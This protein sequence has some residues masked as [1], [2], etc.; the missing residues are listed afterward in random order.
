MGLTNMKHGQIRQSAGMR[1]V[2]FSEKESKMSRSSDGEPQI[3][4]GSI[5]TVGL[6]LMA[7]A[8]VYVLQS[9][10]HAAPWLAIPG[11]SLK[12][13]HPHSF[14]DIPCFRVGSMVQTEC[15][16]PKNAMDSHSWEF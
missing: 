2:R 10:E 16:V 4:C 5:R 13:S 7:P 9:I 6:A 15:L 12:E 1:R 14:G 8:N 3:L 11:S